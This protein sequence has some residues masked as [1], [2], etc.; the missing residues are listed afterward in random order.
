MK[1]ASKSVDSNQTAIHARLEQTVSKH[2][3]HPYLKPVASHTAVAFAEV[4]KT[5][6]GHDCPI[7]LDAC[8]GSGDSSRRLAQHYPGHWIVGIDKSAHRLDKERQMAEPDNLILVRAD[9]NDFYRLATK[10]GWRPERHYI[11]YPNPWPKAEHLGR[12]WHGAPVFP[13]IVGLGGRLELRSNWK[14]YLEEFAAA[15]LVAGHKSK[16]APYDPENY[17]TLF[18][19]KYHES[20]QQIWR[21]VTEL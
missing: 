21:L 20:G 16:L 4:Q 19:K 9:L 18:E 7:I 17:L 2:L 6:A 15:L 12:R 1:Q 14:I 11:L 3:K 13:D 5:L 8:C 10:A